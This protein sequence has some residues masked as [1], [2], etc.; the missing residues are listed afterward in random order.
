MKN[1]PEFCTECAFHMVIADPD[2]S[3]SFNMDDVA[4]ICRKLPNRSRDLSSKYWAD[5]SEFAITD[6]GLRPYQVDKV[7]SPEWCPL[8]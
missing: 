2:P 6:C 4:V 5:K 1:Y 3:D 7:K 8:K